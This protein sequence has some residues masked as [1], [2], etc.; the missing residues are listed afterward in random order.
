MGC[1][2]KLMTARTFSISSSPHWLVQL[3]YVFLGFHP[4][5][6]LRILAHEEKLFLSI[7]STTS[8]ESLDVVLL[9]FVVSNTFQ[10]QGLGPIFCSPLAHHPQHSLCKSRKEEHPR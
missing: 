6:P 10:P 9:G 3:R 7:L 1:L 8:W 5:C 4:W 2:A